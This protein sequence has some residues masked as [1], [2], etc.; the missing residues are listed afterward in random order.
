MNITIYREVLKG[1][2][3][4]IHGFPETSKGGF[5]TI[6]DRIESYL[7]RQ[8]GFQGTNVTNMLQLDLIILYGTLH[9]RFLGAEMS[10]I[11][12]LSH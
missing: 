7:N 1:E 6:L 3:T 11:M 2:S 9:S 12:S 10:C 8:F 5:R 4:G